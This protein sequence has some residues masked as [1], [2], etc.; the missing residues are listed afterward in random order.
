MLIV[1]IGVSG[2]G[3]T[4]IGLELARQ[5]GFEFADADTYHSAENIRKMAA[6]IPLTD[7]D[8]WPWLAKL[9][10]LMKQRAD[11][12]EDLVLACSALRQVY[13]D[14]LQE[15]LQVTWVYLKGSPEAI[16]ERLRE[17]HGHYMTEQL[18]ASQLA[19]LEEPTGVITVNADNSVPEVVR[20]IVAKLSQSQAAG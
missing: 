11:G 5:L 8:R 20:D 2:V 13:R 3:K 12:G 9:H 6:G 7:E 16:R 10:D 1:V 18:L 4:T 17:R 19:T 14:K 15:G